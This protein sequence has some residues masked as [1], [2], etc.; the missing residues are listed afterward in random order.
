MSRRNLCLCNY[1]TQALNKTC[2]DS[3]DMNSTKTQ[4]SPHCRTP[5]HHAGG[6]TVHHHN[7]LRTRPLDP[8]ATVECHQLAPRDGED[9]LHP[10]HPHP[11]TVGLRGL[12]GEACLHPHPDRAGA[13]CHQVAC[14]CTCRPSELATST[15]FSSSFLLLRKSCC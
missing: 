15:F 5:A 14:C 8:T 13:P 6:R 7:N 2:I 3:S 1:D 4:R 11:V 12:M 10:L 9:Q